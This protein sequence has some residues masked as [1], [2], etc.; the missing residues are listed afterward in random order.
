MKPIK[1]ISG[2][3]PFCETF[4]DNVRVPRTQVMGEI[5]RAGLHKVA[6]VSTAQS[7]GR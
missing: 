1:L 2:Y 4:L 3:S 7:E 5:N 6:L